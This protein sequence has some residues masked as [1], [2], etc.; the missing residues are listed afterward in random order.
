M[1][2]INNLSDRRNSVNLTFERNKFFKFN[3]I[4]A[5]LFINKIKYN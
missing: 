2:Y 4:K 5:N 1:K 3:L